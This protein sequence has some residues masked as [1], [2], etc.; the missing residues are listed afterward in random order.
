LTLFGVL[1]KYKL[2]LIWLLLNT[3]KWWTST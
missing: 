3:F 2:S 1:A